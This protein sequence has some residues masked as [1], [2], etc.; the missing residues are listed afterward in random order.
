MTLNHQTEISQVKLFLFHDTVLAESGHF[1][2]TT[3]KTPTRSQG[4]L[5]PFQ[6]QTLVTLPITTQGNWTK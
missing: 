5:L 6:N 1:Q 2:K 4:P 3:G